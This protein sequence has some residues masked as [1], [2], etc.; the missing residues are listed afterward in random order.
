MTSPQI[1]SERLKMEIEEEWVANACGSYSM[2]SSSVTCCRAGL[3]RLIDERNRVTEERNRLAS[4]LNA[5]TTIN[6][7]LLTLAMK[8]CP[9]GHQDWAEILRIDGDP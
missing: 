6:A 4:E 9:P 3:R 8:H 2:T 1:A 5:A 7:R